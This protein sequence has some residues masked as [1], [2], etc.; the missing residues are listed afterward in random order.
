[1]R[2]SINRKQ[3]NNLDLVVLK[4]EYTKTEA[5][6][7][8]A[9]GASLHGFS[10]LIK[11]DPVNIIDNYNSDAQVKKE[12]SSTFKS[13]KLSPFAC[14]IPDGRYTFNEIEYEF[15]TRFMD[16]SAIHG[17]L[18]NKSF[19]LIKESAD[20]KK[21][22]VTLQYDYK[23]DDA[24][25]P[26]YY[27]CEVEYSLSDNNAL[28]VKTIV[29]NLSETTIP[30]ADGWHPYFKLGGKVDDWLLYFTTDGI[31]EFDEKLIPTGRILN[32]NNFSSP[33][34]IE[35]MELDNCFLVKKN[36]EGPACQLINHSNKLTLSFFPDANYPYLQIFTP[37]HRNSIAIENLSAAPDCFNNKMGLTLLSANSSQ[38]FTV[39]Y[40]LSAG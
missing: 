40:Q 6:L 17:L 18:Y 1:M 11:D 36:I 14:R 15:Q 26:Y 37:P 5:A 13:S 32:Y 34:L 24:G 21:A 16:G 23:K 28:E 4:D 29:H 22:A 35:S 10:V 19:A 12:L 38:T 3:E 20:E 27:R 30:I 9:C 7:L 31:L 2:F 33:Q 39:I 8:P 25:Y